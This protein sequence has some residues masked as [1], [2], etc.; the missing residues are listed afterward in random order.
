[1]NELIVM[2]GCCRFITNNSIIVNMEFTKFHYWQ[3]PHLRIVMWVI[4]NIAF[5]LNSFQ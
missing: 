4:Y 3:T 1:M 2:K 5:M